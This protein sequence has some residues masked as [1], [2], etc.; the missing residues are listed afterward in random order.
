MGIMVGGIGC[1]AV[2][3]FGGGGGNFIG[4]FA[5]EG[6]PLTGGGG[7][8]PMP[9]ILPAGDDVAVDG[10]GTIGG[11]GMKCGCGIFGGISVCRSSGEPVTARPVRSIGGSGG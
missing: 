10:G 7:G 1:C 2:M 11:A 6:M 4:I 3:G 8:D 9:S 5:C